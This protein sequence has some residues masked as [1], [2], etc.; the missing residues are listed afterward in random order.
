MN[1]FFKNLRLNVGIAACLLSAHPAPGQDSQSPPGPIES[2]AP[3]LPAPTPRLRKNPDQ[4][5][6]YDEGLDDDLEELR[7]KRRAREVK[8]APPETTWR[9]SLRKKLMAE[10]Q[11]PLP[12]VMMLEV[13]L[14][15]GTVRTQGRT[16]DYTFNPTSHFNFYFRPTPKTLT[17]KPTFW[18]GL[19][20]AA[21]SGVGYYENRPGRYGLTYVGP[22]VAM[23]KLHPRKGTGKS[24]KD[25]A[26]DP[27]AQGDGQGWLLSL[28]LAGLGRIGKS[29]NPYPESMENDFTTSRKVIYDPASVWLEGRYVTVMFGGLGV[30]Y[31]L[32]MQNARARA[33][34]YIGV[35]LAGWY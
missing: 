17:Q 5:P 27:L 29:E 32:G 24:D 15:Y 4:N 35:G 14:L 21:F 3:P 10:A 1:P 18:T 31:I 23:G 28:G 19:R 13:S 11:K 16:R 26:K 8:D 9:E 34:V 20:L 25:L 7:A 12:R 33:M 6:G 22:I 30:N 2:L